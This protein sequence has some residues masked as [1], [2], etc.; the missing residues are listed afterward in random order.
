MPALT[1]QVAPLRC[2]PALDGVG[3]GLG[4]GIAAAAVSRAAGTAQ[5]VVGDGDAGL[6]Y[7]VHTDGLAGEA[8]AGIVALDLYV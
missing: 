8:A 5:L 3:C 6:L 2:R 4:D 7:A 1:H